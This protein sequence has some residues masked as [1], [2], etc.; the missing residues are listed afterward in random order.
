MKIIALGTGTSQGVPVIGCT[1]EVCTST[2]PRDKR[3]RTSVYIEVDNKKILIDIGPDFRSQF[4]ANNL[5]DVDAILIT[6]EHT[7]HIIGLDDIRAINYVQQKSIPIYGEL[8]VL[9]ALRERFS[10]AFGSEHYGKPM[11]ELHEIST[12]PFYLFG[13]RIEPLRIMHGR[14]PILGYKIG[15]FGY[16][17]DANAIEQEVIDR[18]KNIK[19]LIINALRHEEHYSHF[20]LKECLDVIREINPQKAYITH[21]SHQMGKTE[22]WSKELPDNVFPLYDGLE[23]W[24]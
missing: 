11:I 22:N 3:Y 15:D 17:T 1:C 6:H 14:L 12:D 8:R 18:L 24:G 19:V 20:T 16:V 5:T 7:D 2:D 9:N 10:Y 13:N 21:V 23:L 4:L